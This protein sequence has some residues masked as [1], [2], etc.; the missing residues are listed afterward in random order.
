MDKL[1]RVLSGRDTAEEE[2]ETGIMATVR[3]AR[4]RA[5]YR[6]VFIYITLFICIHSCADKRGIDLKLVD[7]HQRLCYL[8]YRWHSPDAAR[9]FCSI[10]ARWPTHVCRLLYAGQCSVNGQ[11]MLSDGS[12]E[13]DAN[14]V[15]VD[16]SHCHLF[17]IVQHHHD[18]GGSSC[19][20]YN[21]RF[22]LYNKKHINCHHY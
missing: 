18:I 4:A 21:I 10:F 16:Q 3:N 22:H 2:E 9:I 12:A 11:H 1:K 17:G 20:L 5:T 19:G 7:P 15:C 6:N 13:T 14:H 8:F